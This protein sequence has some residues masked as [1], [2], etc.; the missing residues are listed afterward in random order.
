LQAKKRGEEFFIYLNNVLT[1]LS[2]EIAR[3]FM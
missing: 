3:I 1:F 2:V